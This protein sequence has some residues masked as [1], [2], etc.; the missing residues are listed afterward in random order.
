MY[1]LL[2]A[3]LLSVSLNGL[4]TSVDIGAVDRERQPSLEQ[5][6]EPRDDKDVPHVGLRERVSGQVKLTKAKNLYVLVNPL[7]NPTTSRNTWWV[8]E[9]VSVD[10]DRFSAICQFGEL[11]EGQHEY[12]AITVFESD[13]TYDVG[14]ILNGLPRG[15]AWSSFKIVRRD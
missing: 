3:I 10:G 4:V 6:R 9:R 14:Q 15:K 8:Q 5:L 11:G 12:F 13:A 1:R 2:S 7:S